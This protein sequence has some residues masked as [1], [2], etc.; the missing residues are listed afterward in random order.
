MQKLLPH[1]LKGVIRRPW[2]LPQ[3]NDASEL[4]LEG[5]RWS[6]GHSVATIRRERPCC[7]DSFRGFVSRRPKEQ[8]VV[9]LAQVNAIQEKRIMTRAGVRR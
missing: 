5:F 6:I 7:V 1:P 2:L 3:E 4:M 9:V 8:K